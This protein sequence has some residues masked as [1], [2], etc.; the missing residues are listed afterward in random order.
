MN[1]QTVDEIRA[2]LELALL[3]ADCRCRA[4]EANF[5]LCADAESLRDWVEALAD[6]ATI[7]KADN[8]VQGWVEQNVD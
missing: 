2:H 7:E 3:E 1:K 4:T 5:H 8:I 6:R